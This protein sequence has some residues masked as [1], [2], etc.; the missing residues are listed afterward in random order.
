M[1][2]HGAAGRRRIGAARDARRRAP[3][4]RGRA[5]ALPDAGRVRA[6]RAARP[7]A[8]GAGGAAVRGHGRHGRR[9]RGLG[10]GGHGARRGGAVRRDGDGRRRGG[11]PRGDRDAVPAGRVARR[12]R[13]D[14]HP[15]DGRARR[16][17]RAPAD[18]RRHLRAGDQER[19]ADERAR[20][21]RPDPAR[22]DRARRRRPEHDRGAEPGHHDRARGGRRGSRDRG[23]VDARRA[24][25]A[26]DLAVGA[27]RADRCVLP[28][29]S[30]ARADPGTRQGPA[31][32]VPGGRPGHGPARRHARPDDHLHAHRCGARPGRG[33]PDRGVRRVRVGGSGAH[34]GG[35]GRR[36]RARDPAGPASVDG[37]PI[38]RPPT[39]TGPR[40]PA[41]GT[42]TATGTG[43]SG[44]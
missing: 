41:T 13:R 34:G 16:R 23:V 27:A 42:D 5:A 44:C 36:P 3:D 1:G 7:H 20:P 32:R 25:P 40:S 43:T 19:G 37:D 31:R 28:A 38:R 9:R 8:R 26:V 15:H 22:P 24:A 4:R 35:R 6:H 17:G 12:R 2:G 11:R 29:R 39:G 18:G 14:R 33:R 10:R 30:A 21:A